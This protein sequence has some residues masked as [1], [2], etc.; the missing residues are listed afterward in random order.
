MSSLPN[1]AQCRPPIG[2]RTGALEANLDRLAPL[3][4][5]DGRSTNAHPLT[6][7]QPDVIGGVVAVLLHQLDHST[8][9][10]GQR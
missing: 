5:R 2:P 6:V 8:V 3:E 9:A 7:G 1:I 10:G 4:L